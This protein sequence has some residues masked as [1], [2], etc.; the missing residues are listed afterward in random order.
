MLIDTHCHLNDKKLLY[1]TPDIVLTSEQ[2]RMLGYICIGTDIETSKIAVREA[3][4]FAPVYATVGLHPDYAMDYDEETEKVFTTLAEHKKVV[5]FG[6]IGLDY[7][8]DN[9]PP[10]EIQKEVFAKQIRLADKLGL[11]LVIHIRDAFGD[12]LEI[13]KENREYI[14]HGGVIHCYSGSVEMAKIFLEMGFYLSF[15]GVITFKNAK[16]N[17][18]V[19]SIMPL[20]RI[21]VETDS[22][23]LSPEPFRGKLNEPKN[24]NIV[25]DKISE[26][27]GIDR[28]EL[29]EQVNYNART[30]F[31]KLDI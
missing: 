27:R 26:L 14:N 7:Y 31:K 12:A 20:D 10:R 18:E 24:V 17:V 1:F 9:Q 25:V 29:V 30:L 3:D 15:N 4:I 8:G 22:P 2:D 23:Y 6:E 16:K 5:A 19:L 13:L 28:A 11:P 21:L